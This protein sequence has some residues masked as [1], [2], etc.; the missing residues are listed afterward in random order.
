[1][2]KWVLASEEVIVQLIKTKCLPVLYYG[3][4]A[5]PLNK[6][7]IKAL[8]YVL[9][10]SFSQWRNDRGAE[11]GSCPRAQ[12]TKGRKIGGA[13]VGFMQLLNKPKVAYSFYRAMHF[14]AYARSWDRMS[15]VR[16][17]VRPSVRL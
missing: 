17:S 16:P 8:D 2:E 15:S 6:S 4:E 7:E 5:C 1:M 14:S 10:S 11:G 9:F 3:L 13:K 12:Q